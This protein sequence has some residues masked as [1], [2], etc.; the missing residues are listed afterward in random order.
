MGG[1]S[2]FPLVAVVLDV[3]ELGE[4][5]KLTEGVQGYPWHIDNK[6]YTADVQLCTAHTRTIGNQE[7]ADSV[8][9]LVIHFD[10]TQVCLDAT[11]SSFLALLL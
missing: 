11:H 10:A 1:Y 8:E 2:L 4:G 9:A 7:F 3:A 5:T 6:Y